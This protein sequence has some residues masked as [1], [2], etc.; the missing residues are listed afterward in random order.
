MET[1][2]RQF[3]RIPESNRLRRSSARSWNRGDVGYLEL[4]LPSVHLLQHLEIRKNYNPSIFAFLAKSNL[5]VAYV[6]CMNIIR[7]GSGEFWRRENRPHLPRS[8]KACHLE[9]LNFPSMLGIYPSCQAHITPTWRTF[10]ESIET[11]RDTGG[12]IA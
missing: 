11:Q 8:L 4:L 2:C 1:P 6:A 5:G 10:F 3:C 7:Q 12:L 9:R